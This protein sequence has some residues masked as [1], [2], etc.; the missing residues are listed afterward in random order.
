V[1]VEISWEAEEV[2]VGGWG[3]G[4]G[5]FC[6]LDGGDARIVPEHVCGVPCV[7]GLAPVAPGGVFVEEFDGVVD[8]YVVEPLGGGRG[9]AE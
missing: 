2:I 3:V 9:W 1:E 5:G 4:E 6:G 7:Q 8:D